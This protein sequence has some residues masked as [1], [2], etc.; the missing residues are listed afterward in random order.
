MSTIKIPTSCGQLL[1]TLWM[2]HHS[3]LAATQKLICYYLLPGYFSITLVLVVSNIV[4]IQTWL[5]P[6]LSEKLSSLTPSSYSLL[7]VL[8]SR[9]P[10]SSSWHCF[11]FPVYLPVPEFP[12]DFSPFRYSPGPT[13]LDFWSL[14]KCCHLL[15]MNMYLCTLFSSPQS[16]IIFSLH[17]SFTFSLKKRNEMKLLL[18]FFWN[19]FLDKTQTWRWSNGNYKFGLNENCLS[20]KITFLIWY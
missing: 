17:I 15:R 9:L 13:L 1:L 6:I 16:S 2:H 4:T 11:N 18:C 7:V 8:C 14:S 19:I 12:C 20:Q 5:C 10:L 3:F